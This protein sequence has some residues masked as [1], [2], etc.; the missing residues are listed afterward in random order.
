VVGTDRGVNK[1]VGVVNCPSERPPGTAVKPPAPV[2]KHRTGWKLLGRLQAGQI[3]RVGS[4]TIGAILRA[5]IVFFWVAYRNVM[6]AVSTAGTAV[7]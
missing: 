2:I 6:T 4:S 1:L 3:A 5:F 7:A